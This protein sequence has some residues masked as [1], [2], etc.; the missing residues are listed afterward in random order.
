MM[1]IQCFGVASVAS[2][3]RSFPARRPLESRSSS[4]ER[5]PSLR[6]EDV[7]LVDSAGKRLGTSPGSG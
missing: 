4:L 5:L 1:C 7:S 3:L 2:R 6:S